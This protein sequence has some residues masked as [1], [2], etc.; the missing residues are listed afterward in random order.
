VP[1][2][3]VIARPSTRDG[4]GF[5][6]A[7]GNAGAAVAIDV[8][9]DCSA[10]QLADDWVLV[11]EMIHTAMPDLKGPHHWLEEGLSTYVEPLARV[12]AGLVSPEELWTDWV[13]GMPNGL[14]EKGDRGLDRTPTWGRTY[15][16][17]ALFCLVADVEIRSRTNG[18]KSLDDALRA[19]VAA[20]GNISTAW[21]IE[22]V[23]EVGDGATG[24]PVLHELYAKMARDP[25]PVDLAAMW[26]RLGVVR[27][28]A[29]VTF[30]DNAPLA[31]VRRAM[32]AS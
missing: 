17:G 27:S 2:L 26:K 25:A 16:G 23:L 12:R 28:G 21:P 3:A 15:W 8:G 6:T 10:E 20:G 18:K 11:H 30:D 14:P 7:I 32:T 24:V 31:P 29:S 19:I 22:R 13:R 1:R 9:Q 4:V 5:G